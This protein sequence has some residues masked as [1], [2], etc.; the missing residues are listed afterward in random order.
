M[1]DIRNLTSK[2][3]SDAEE[4]RNKAIAEAATETEKIREEYIKKA[5]AI[6]AEYAEKAKLAEASSETSTNAAVLMQHR[7]MMLETKNALIAEVF[8]KARSKIAALDKNGRAALYAGFAS[9]AVCDIPG[10]KLCIC[11]CDEE[12]KDAILD[13]VN[14]TASDKGMPALS[15]SEKRLDG[16]CGIVLVY[17]NLEYNCMLDTMIKSSYSELSATAVRVLFS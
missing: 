13:S 11:K 17:G 15:L 12:Y 2:I 8:S 7:N 5:D 16:D 9:D 6:K 3:L 10:G 4:Y 1:N 14:K